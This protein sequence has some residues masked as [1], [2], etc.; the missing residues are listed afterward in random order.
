MAN[1][2]WPRLKA[3]CVI[4]HGRSYLFSVGTDPAKPETFLVPLGGGVEFGETASASVVREIKE[5][6]GVVIEKPYLLGVLENIFNYDG[7]AHHEV[8]FCFIVQVADRDQ[9]PF[10]GRESN[11]E[12]IPLRWLSLEEL[13]T[14]PIPVYPEGIVSLILK[15]SAMRDG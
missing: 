5:E 6:I 13:R 14:T 12:D 7:A 9:V 4:R 3:I 10:A 2:Q 8:V 11:G 15:R 1:Q